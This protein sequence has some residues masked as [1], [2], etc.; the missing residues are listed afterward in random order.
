MQHT[1][2]GRQP[3]LSR[4]RMIPGKVLATL[5]GGLMSR[6]FK[7]GAPTYMTSRNPMASSFRRGGQAVT[8]NPV[9]LREA[10]SW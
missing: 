5:A 2:A 3:S 9:T 4:V 6:V 1:D 10:V 8:V 7:T